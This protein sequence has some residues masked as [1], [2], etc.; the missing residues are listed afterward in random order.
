MGTTM[1]LA[2]T[3]GDDLLVTHLG[4]SRVYLLR[5]GQLRRLT[6]DHTA[7]RPA[8]R[9]AWVSAAR[10]RRVLTHAIG[11]P[12]TGGEPDLHHYKLADGDR[13]LLCTDGLT[14]MV[15]DDLIAGELG[16]A[17]SAAAACQSLIDLALGRGGRDNVTVVVAGYRRRAP[18]PECA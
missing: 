12:E 4:D 17:S 1:L 18:K 3:L 16:R 7:G 13:L 2:L 11:I 6:Q 14:D 9:S 10:I 5:Q 15:T 8:A